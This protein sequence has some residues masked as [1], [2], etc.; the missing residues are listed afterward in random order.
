MGLLE[1]LGLRKSRPTETDALAAYGRAMGKVQALEQLMRLALGEH[2]VRRMQRPGAKPDPAVTGAGLLDMDFGR[3][4]QR[5]CGKFRFDEEMKEIMNQAR[6]FRNSL[7]HQFWI[8]HLLDLNSPRGVAVVIRHAAILER[9][10][11]WVAEALIAHTG[12]QVK[13]YVEFMAAQRANGESLAGWEAQLAEVE[14]VFARVAAERAQNA[15]KA[16]DRPLTPKP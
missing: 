8:H 10:I 2:E 7:A 1:R 13:S 14:E 11:D 4:E 5:V 15:A 9:Q 16:G 3:L 12:V 6:G